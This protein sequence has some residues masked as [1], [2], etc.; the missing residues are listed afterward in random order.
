MPKYYRQEPNPHDTSKQSYMVVASTPD[1]R[2]H[3]AYG[4]MVA[5]KKPREYVEH[6]TSKN[7][8]GG[9]WG[10]LASAVGV[11]PE[12]LA[13]VSSDHSNTE[14]RHELNTHI[15]NALDVLE[16]SSLTGL[17][18]KKEWERHVNRIKAHPLANPETLFTEK[19]PRISVESAFV[20]P[21]IRH[22]FPTMMAIAQQDNPDAVVVPSKNLSRHSA[23]IA[24]N[25]ARRGLLGDAPKEFKKANPIEFSSRKATK[26]ALDWALHPSFSEVPETEVSSAREA[27][28]TQLRGPKKSSTTISPAQF[29]HPKLFG[30]DDF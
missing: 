2:G 23:K 1:E 20:D 9:T 17:N 28:R 15:M 21:G 14:Q 11:S 18:K 30:D 16:D 7:E 4:D 29:N 24:T 22:T 10:K 6:W 5:Y 8:I 26:E 25:A 3:F 27:L 19:P 13:H 12:Y